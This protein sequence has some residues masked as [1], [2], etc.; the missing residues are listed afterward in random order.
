[1]RD[2]TGQWVERTAMAAV[3]VMS[4]A[5][6]SSGQKSTAEGAQP[7]ANPALIEPSVEAATTQAVQLVDVAKA[8]ALAADPTVAVIDVR[9]QAEFAEGHLARA[10]VID[11]S[12]AD[13]GGRIAQLDRSATYLVYC[14]SGN[15]SGQA[16]AIMAALGFTNVYELDGGISAWQSAGAPIVT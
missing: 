9:T 7:T 13:F 11:V 15:R 1:M 10:E 2:R 14:H 3:A 12:A 8:V 5:A 6:C 4:L 16:T